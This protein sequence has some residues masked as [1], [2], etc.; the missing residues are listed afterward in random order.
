[1][2]RV[3]IIISLTFISFLS[4]NAQGTKV[5]SIK[6]TASVLL[7][8]KVINQ[9][10]FNK[11]DSINIVLYQERKVL[12]KRKSMM[13]EGEFKK[14]HSIISKNFTNSLKEILGTDRFNQWE[15]TRY[16]N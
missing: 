3:F 16:S 4:I 11:I 15:K 14:Q 7:K 2:K 10:E 6:E 13:S 5:L 1:M 12:D 9:D 8:D